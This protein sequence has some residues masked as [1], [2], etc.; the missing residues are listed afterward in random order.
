M[1]PCLVLTRPHASSE[2]FAAMAKA[3]GWRGDTLI[4]PLIEIALAPPPPQVLQ[5]ARVLIFTSQHAVAAMAQASP[6]RDWPVWAVGP[7]TAEAARNLGFSHVHQAGGDAKALLADLA[8]AQ[9]EGPFLHLR[10]DHVA[11]DIVAALRAQGHQAEGRI[12]YG[13]VARPLDPSA[14]TRI[15]QGGDLVLAVF[16]PRSAALLVAALESVNLSAARLHLVAISQAAAQPA[17]GLPLSGC[18][19]AQ[20]PDSQGMLASVSATQA[21][22]EPLEKPS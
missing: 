16:S 1:R 17:A 11:A 8:Q 7:R 12:V 4:A 18:Q 9:A 19:I 21:M 6:D 14:Q 10:G 20:T 3:A 15:G 22:L 2:A 5:K 13:Q